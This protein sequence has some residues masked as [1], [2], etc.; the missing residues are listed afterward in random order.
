MDFNDEHA[1]ET[2]KS[3]ISISVEGLKTLQ[4]I[5]GGAVVALLAYLGQVSNRA[6][7]AGRVGCPLILFVLGLTAGTAAFVTSYETQLTLYNEDVRP[8]EYKGS[9]SNRWLRITFGLA[10]L[11]LLAFAVGAFVAVRILARG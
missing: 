2:Y 8:N 10:V 6:Q 3:L 9:R 7:L 5:N 11:S 4:L 1:I